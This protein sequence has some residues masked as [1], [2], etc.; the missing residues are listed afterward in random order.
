MGLTDELDALVRIQSGKRPYNIKDVRW[1]LALALDIVELQ[2]EYI[3]GIPR[4]SRFL[5]RQTPFSWSI[6]IN[7]WSGWLK[8][9]TR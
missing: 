9:L 6:T 3:G 7:R 4:V 5:N 8:E 2:T 1:A